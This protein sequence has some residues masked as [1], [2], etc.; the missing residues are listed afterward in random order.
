[1]YK[2]IYTYIKKNYTQF[3]YYLGIKGSSQNHFYCFLKQNR[4]LIGYTTGIQPISETTMHSVL[5]FS[6]QFTFCWSACFFSSIHL[7]KKKVGR[8]LIARIFF[9]GFYPYYTYLEQ[10]ALNLFNL[11]LFLFLKWLNN[12]LSLLLTLSGAE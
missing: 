1:M 8:R 9:L 5:L 10:F 12:V 7:N 11:L 4:Y 6:L 3:W 2:I